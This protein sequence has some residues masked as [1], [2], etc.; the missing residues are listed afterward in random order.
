MNPTNIVNDGVD[1]IDEFLLFLFLGLPDFP[2]YVH[3]GEM[4]TEIG[5]ALLFV[6]CD[7]VLCHGAGVTTD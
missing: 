3:Q 2:R 5:L 6:L 4:D 1:V 7:C